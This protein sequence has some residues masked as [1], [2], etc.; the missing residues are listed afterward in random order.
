MKRLRAR[1][2]SGQKMKSSRLGKKKYKKQKN[3]KKEKKEY[4]IKKYMEIAFSTET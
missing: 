2:V 4:K 3:Y 1:A